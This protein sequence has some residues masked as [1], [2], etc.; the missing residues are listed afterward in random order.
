MKA[1]GEVEVWLQA[2][3]RL[4]LDWGGWS[5]SH[6]GRLT[7]SKQLSVPVAWNLG[8]LQCRARRSLRSPVDFL[9]HRWHYRASRHV[10]PYVNGLCRDHLTICLVV[11]AAASGFGPRWKIV[12]G[13]PSKGGPSKN[14]YTKSEKLALSCR[15]TWASSE[16]VKLCSRQIMI[17]KDKYK[18]GCNTAGPRTTS[19]R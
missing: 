8:G 4:A 5:A 19:R 17:L 1:H 15:V 2:F 3:L 11:R 6:L 16:R 9:G 13:H 12:F 7:L 14:I 18:N 10:R